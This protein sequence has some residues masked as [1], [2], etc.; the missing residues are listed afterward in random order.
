M[1]YILNK[2]K[3]VTLYFKVSWLHVTC[4]YFYNNNKLCIIAGK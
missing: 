1:R 3:L 2:K 4:T